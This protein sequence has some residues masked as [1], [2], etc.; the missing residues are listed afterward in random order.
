MCPTEILYELI[1]SLKQVTFD[2][3]QYIAHTNSMID[4][5]YFIEEGKVEVS[6]EFEGNTF[7]FDT[8]YPG[9]AINYRAVFLRDTMY[10]NLRALTDCKL[11]KISIDELMALV[12][13]FSIY[14]HKDKSESEKKAWV[15]DFSTRVSLAYNR[16][17]KAERSFPLDYLLKYQVKKDYEQEDTGKIYR[18]NLL[19]NVSMRIVNEI[20]ERQKRPKL[21]DVMAIYRARKDEPNAKENFQEKFIKLYGDNTE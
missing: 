1:F 5:I 14:T 6:T 4:S 19:K 13:K 3:E 16:Y 21:E 20:R 17:L 12:N 8:L 7:V 15:R 11:L 2:K 18:K 9:T 10:V